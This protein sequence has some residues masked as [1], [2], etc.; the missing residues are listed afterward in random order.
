MLMLMLA[1]QYHILSV[2]LYDLF[3]D[4]DKPNL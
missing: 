1:Y 4:G 3:S 2:W